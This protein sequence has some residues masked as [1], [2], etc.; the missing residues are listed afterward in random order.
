MHT[1][2]YVLLAPDWPLA[3]RLG[4][5]HNTFPS[6]TGLY[7]HKRYPAYDFWDIRVILGLEASYDYPIIIPLLS[8]TINGL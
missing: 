6:I 1:F 3:P 2:C 5:C 8:H 4:L 7:P